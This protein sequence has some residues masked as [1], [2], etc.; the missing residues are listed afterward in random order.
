MASLQVAGRYPA[1]KE[2]TV[3]EVYLASAHLDLLAKIAPTTQHLEI[4]VQ[5]NSAAPSRTQCI[6][7]WPPT[8]NFFLFGET[9][10]SVAS[11]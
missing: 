4:Q 3:R 2:I 1:L 8:L 9:T 7:T 5:A 6:R 10:W 11:H